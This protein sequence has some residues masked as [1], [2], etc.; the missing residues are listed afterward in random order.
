MGILNTARRLGAHLLTPPSD[1]PSPAAENEVARLR[2]EL[3]QA[4]SELDATVEVAN[5]RLRALVDLE[6]R[7][8]DVWIES[9]LRIHAAETRTAAA[10]RPP[11]C[12]WRYNAE[13]EPEVAFASTMGDVFR[14]RIPHFGARITMLECDAERSVDVWRSNETDA[15]EAVDALAML[16]EV[17]GEDHWIDETEGR[18]WE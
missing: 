15:A 16:A 1:R 13:G 17:L 9:M 6:T 5:E 3:A 18:T 4:R 11:I 8:S 14:L 2:L 12:A 7:F 10:P